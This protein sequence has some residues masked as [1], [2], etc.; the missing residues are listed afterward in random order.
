[1]FTYTIVLDP[2]LDEGGYTVTVPAL[3]GCIT[4]GETVDECV[5]NAQE[6]I[7]LYLAELTASGKPI[8]EE[9]EQPKLVTVTV[10]A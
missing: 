1:M 3:P 8:P 4:E 10:A 6:A 9:R 5:A 2:D 7:Q